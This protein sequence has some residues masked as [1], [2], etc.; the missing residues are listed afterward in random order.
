[1]EGIG[2]TNKLEKIESREEK[3]RAAERRVKEM[4]D[5]NME[6]GGDIIDRVRENPSF[7]GLEERDF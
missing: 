2:Q 1:M 3:I 4:F 5:T 6:A 7:R